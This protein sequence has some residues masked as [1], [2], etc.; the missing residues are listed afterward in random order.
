ML[1]V[2]NNRN[3]MLWEETIHVLEG[4]YENETRVLKS[5]EDPRLINQTW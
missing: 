4:K 3:K 2:N 5:M 1:I